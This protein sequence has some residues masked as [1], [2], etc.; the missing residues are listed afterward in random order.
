MLFAQGSIRN[1]RKYVF[2]LS[3]LAAGWS[4]A[5]GAAF[6]ADAG[7]S[8]YQQER[9]ACT[10]GLSHQDRA[11]CLKEAAAARA[12]AKRGK[13]NGGTA[14]YEQNAIIRCN[15][16]PEADR[17]DCVRRVRGEGKVSGSVET[18]GIYRETTT[19]IVAPPAEPTAPESTSR[20]MP[21]HE[22]MRERMHERRQA[23]SSGN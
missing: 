18:G 15:A 9:A 13:L 6:A 10:S 8:I 17:Q 16:L 1:A 2:G 19:I 21:M 23:P 20:P 7:A 22:P 12:E 11:T 4:F 5:S 14:A 3:L